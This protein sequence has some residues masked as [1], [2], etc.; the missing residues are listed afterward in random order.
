MSTSRGPETTRIEATLAI[1]EL[2]DDEVS[3]RRRFK[4]CARTRLSTSQAEVKYWG[5]RLR[6]DKGMACDPG[7]IKAALARLTV[8]LLPESLAGVEL[9]ERVSSVAVAADH[10]ETANGAAAKESVPVISTPTLGETWGT[11]WATTLMS[12]ALRRV[13]QELP[14][15]LDFPNLDA[16]I[17]EVYAASDAE[18]QERYRRSVDAWTEAA[19]RE[20]NSNGSLAL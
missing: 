4:S 10:V 19:L 14:D 6:D 20:I 17:E 5:E 9:A 11:E 13:V 3:L 8:A 7:T 16:E 18:D 15:G 1:K 12:Q 2:L